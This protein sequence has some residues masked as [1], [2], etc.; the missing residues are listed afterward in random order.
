MVLKDK[1]AKRKSRKDENIFI[2]H[3]PQ[4][5]SASLKPVNY[6]QPVEI[7]NLHLSNVNKE[8]FD[9]KKVKQEKPFTRL[10][11]ILGGKKVLQK[12]IQSQMDLVTL[13]DKGITKDALLHLAKYLSFS[14]N[15]MAQLLPVTE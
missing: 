1:N 15:Q 9:Y 5:G 11:K 12:S 13:S 4:F 3:K 2:V 10:S 6:I 14:M 8:I 7:N